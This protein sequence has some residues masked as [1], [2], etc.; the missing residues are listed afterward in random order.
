MTGRAIAICYLLAAGLVTA[1]CGG[2][3]DGQASPSGG[4]ATAKSDLE[5]TVSERD[6]LFVDQRLKDATKAC[7]D[8]YAEAGTVERCAAARAD[9]EAAAAAETPPPDLSDRIESAVAACVDTTI[10]STI[11]AP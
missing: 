10:T 3:S 7:V 8:E 6:R 2:S 11:P 5:L 9:L 1:G 4:C